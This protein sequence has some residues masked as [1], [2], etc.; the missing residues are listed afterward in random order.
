MLFIYIMV[1]RA[2]FMRS[3]HFM[4]GDSTHCSNI[5][6]LYCSCLL[7]AFITINT[8]NLRQGN[9]DDELLFLNKRTAVVVTSLLRNG[10]D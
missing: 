10:G 5:L 7:S 1:L 4:I 8:L 6:T 9:L 3:V 2:Y